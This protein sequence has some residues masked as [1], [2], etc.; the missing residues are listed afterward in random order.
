[1]HFLF[2]LICASTK[3]EFGRLY[4]LICSVV[5]NVPHNQLRTAGDIASFKLRDEIE[6][7]ASQPMKTRILF[8]VLKGYFEHEN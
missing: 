1:M 3:N 8:R 6:Q 5:T 7:A 4:L 2:F